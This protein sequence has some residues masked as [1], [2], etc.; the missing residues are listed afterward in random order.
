MKQDTQRKVSLNRISIENDD[1]VNKMTLEKEKEQLERYRSELEREKKE[2]MKEVERFLAEKKTEEKLLSLMKDT[3]QT[4]YC[5]YGKHSQCRCHQ[6]FNHKI[7]N[8]L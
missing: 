2:L 4:R 5:N 6:S 8:K 7:I 3:K 1:N